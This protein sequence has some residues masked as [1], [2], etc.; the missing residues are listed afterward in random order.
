MAAVSDTTEIWKAFVFW[1]F[2]CVIYENT[3]LIWLSE[4][5]VNYT[6]LQFYWNTTT[7]NP[8]LSAV[9]A[10]LYL[11]MFDYTE[12]WQNPQ[13]ESSKLGI[14]SVISHKRVSEGLMEDKLTS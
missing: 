7:K 12:I 11:K 14:K 8:F 9:Q 1:R 6:E 13:S 4:K 5:G 10:N 2:Q 3:K